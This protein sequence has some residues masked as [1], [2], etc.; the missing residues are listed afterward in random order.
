MKPIDTLAAAARDWDALI[1][2]ASSLSLGDR[3]EAFTA[4][5]VHLYATGLRLPTAGP[6]PERLP[7]P[8]WPSDWPGFQV[9]EPGNPELSVL[10]RGL[11]ADIAMGLSWYERDPDQ[12]AGWWRQTFDER[13]GTLAVASLPRLHL[14]VATCRREVSQSASL[15]A[16][17]PASEPEPRPRPLTVLAPLDEPTPARTPG[18]LLAQEPLPPERRPTGRA[19]AVLGGTGVLG[20]RCEPHAQGLRVKAI[21][22]TGPAAQ[23]IEVD[24]LLVEIDGIPLAG[25]S[26]EGAQAALSSRPDQSRTVRLRRGAEERTVRLTAVVPTALG[27]A[28]GPVKLLV[29][30]RDAAQTVLDTLSDLG[31]ALR[32]SPEQE[33][34]I[35]IVAPPGTADALQASL[36]D[37][38]DQG[39]W[40]IL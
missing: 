24:D 1:R 36:R 18:A 4:H 14:A 8:D 16:P 35:E 38:A 22:P 17:T 9:F 3:V 2:A 25:L 34:L 27:A 33:G 26:M 31:V 40:E 12:G 39:W 23:S 21:H 5:L 30:D 20:V 32:T 10:I 37:G 28:P 11:S 29:L 15:V 7:S 6:A 19:R 13:W